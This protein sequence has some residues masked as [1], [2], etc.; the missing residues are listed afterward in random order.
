[1]INAELVYSYA[2]V[3]SFNLE[4]YSYYTEYKYFFPF[5]A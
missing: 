5:I 2:T 1:M 4:N 3:K